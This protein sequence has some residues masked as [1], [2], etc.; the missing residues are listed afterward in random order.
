MDCMNARLEQD[1][2]LSSVIKAMVVPADLYYG[3]LQYNTKY[4]TEDELDKF[5]Y[6][7]S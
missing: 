7:Q 2:A 5:I 6:I 4:L 1:D 3:N